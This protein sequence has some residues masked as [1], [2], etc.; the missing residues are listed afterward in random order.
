MYGLAWSVHVNVSQTPFTSACPSH[1]YVTPLDERART[2]CLFFLGPWLEDS[3]SLGPLDFERDLYT[4]AIVSL[5]GHGLPANG[6]SSRDV[7]GKTELTVPGRISIWLPA[8][9]SG[10]C[11]SISRDGLAK[12]GP[13]PCRGAGSS[14]GDTSC[15][16]P[17]WRATSMSQLGGG[18][19]R[20]ATQLSQ[21]GVFRGP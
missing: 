16:D 9:I 14:A 2:L 3:S 21:T 5:G 7:D 18:L 6:N 13:W 11:L 20:W 17:P 10:R 1:L 12:A 19:E 8:K 15:P 4:V